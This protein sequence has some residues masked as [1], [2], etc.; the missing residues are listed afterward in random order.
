MR[1]RLGGVC[2]T[3]EKGAATQRG[4]VTVA[5]AIGKEVGIPFVRLASI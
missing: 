5:V 3:G 4:L 1:A 2:I